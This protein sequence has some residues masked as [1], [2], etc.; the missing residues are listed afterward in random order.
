MTKTVIAAAAT[1]FVVSCTL[2][3]GL[4]DPTGQRLMHIEARVE[5]L[6][7][8]VGD[9]NG[10]LEAHPWPTALQSYGTPA[11]AALLA[12]IVVALLERLGVKKG[13]TPNAPE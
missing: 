10:E 4:G 3:P 13:A 8:Q 2:L 1:L 6:D 5:N 11:G 12:G 7:D 9:L